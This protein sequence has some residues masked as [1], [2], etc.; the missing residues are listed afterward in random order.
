[1]VIAVAVAA[2]L[3]DPP[4]VYAPM[5]AVSQ[6]YQRLLMVVPLGA[7]APVARGRI[8]QRRVRREPMEAEPMR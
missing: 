2:G 3:V 4:M 6:K 7:V 5:V 8:V 1:M